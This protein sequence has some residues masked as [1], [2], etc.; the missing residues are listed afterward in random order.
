MIA[1]ALLA[2]VAAATFALNNA[3]FRRGALTGTV[4]QAMAISLGL[5]VLLSFIAVLV[6]GAWGEMAALPA[7]STFMLCAAGILHF[8]WGR[9]C[10]FRATKAMGANL[11]GPVQQSSLIITLALA[12]FVLGETL[13][14]LRIL[15][16]GLI[17]LGPAIS[18]RARHATID[19]E[20]PAPAFV[21]RYAEGYTF[22]ALSATGYGSS[23]ILVRAALE[24]TSI[25]T[26]LAGGFI[27]YLAAGAVMALALFWPGRVAHI[28]AVDA[29]SAKWFAASGVLVSLSQMAGYVALALAPVSIVTP[30]QRL[31]LVFRVYANS[32]LNREHEVIG[33][34]IWV[35]TGIAMVGVLFLTV[36]T[37]WALAVLPLPA[38]VESVLAWEWP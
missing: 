35:A 27:A 26:S 34:R 16:I 36:S 6:I 33:P 13:T 18:L 20:A 5:G 17:F 38:A 29:V 11:V 7:L 9:Y 8:A 32:V 28:R 3:A 10:N 12:V 4:A 24:N 14:P 23:P 22:A 15:G 19:A 1:G 2:L 30:I 37:D 25:A 21:P 31:S